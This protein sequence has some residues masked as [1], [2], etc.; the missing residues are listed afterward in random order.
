MYNTV[1]TLLEKGNSISS[2]SRELGMDR[3]TVRK[4]RDNIGKEIMVPKIER[5]SVLDPYREIII[6]YLTEKGLT[7][8]LIHRNLVEDHGVNISYSCVKKY[9]RK[10]KCPGLPYVPLLS[11]PGEE[12]QVD[13]GYAGYFYDDDLKRRIKIWV[14]CM[15][16]SN[17]R[18][19]YYEFVTRQ[20]I[21]T[22]LRC[23]INAFEYFGGA[24]RVVKLDNL[25]SG[26]LQ[27]NFYEP[28]AQEEYAGMLRYYGSSPF[29]CRV[30]TPEEKGKIE[31]GVKYVKRNFLKGLKTNNLRE[32][33][34]QLRV[35][36]EEVCNKRIH[37]TIKK[38]PHEVFINEEKQALMPLPLER[39]E[40]WQI[41][42]RKVNNYGHIYYRYNHYSVPHNYIYKDV[43]IKSNGKLLRIFDEELNEI[44]VHQ[45]SAMT[46]EFITQ[47][48]HNPKAQYLNI[49]SPYA[50]K[51]KSYGSNIYSFYVRLRSAF[52][53]S[54]SR[55]MQGVFNLCKKYGEDIVDAACKRANEF[56]ILSYHS[57]KKIC[58]DGT[59]IKDP[60][61]IE[62]VI[63]GGYGNDLKE[64][65][66]LT[67]GG[68]NASSY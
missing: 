32:A 2:I 8:V 18:K 30:K 65:D 25:K 50:E 60:G 49:D 19:S 54:S 66:I 14:F 51:A 56:N 52:P 39:Y 35:W 67:N 44:A 33:K 29:I 37:G 16:L 55:S 47:A 36:Q 58:E 61:C 11:P 27:P 17:S 20:D 63:A 15:V 64:Y 3:K 21:P 38:V 43:T 41:E 9:L 24:T 4:I 59:Y 10:L 53:H 6:N 23:H 45:V 48:S 12:A 46:G 1:K 5:K 28:L 13:F 34:E 7:G 40:T 68:I 22:F 57:V 62:S 31:S 26:V 42:K